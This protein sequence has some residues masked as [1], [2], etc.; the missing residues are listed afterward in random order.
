VSVTAEARQITGEA[1][2]TEGAF[3]D[4]VAARR[5]L[6][7]AGVPGLD[8][9]HP[10]NDPYLAAQCATMACAAHVLRA[11]VIRTSRFRG[12]AP[13]VAA[14][15]FKWLAD[16]DGEV[17]ARLRRLALRIA[18]DIPGLDADK[19]LAAAQGLRAAAPGR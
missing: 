9:L 11:D 18:C 8:P 12:G 5:T 16:H 13:P 10:V 2:V 7:W 6:W 17:D 4:E 1:R 15:F 3:A 14:D 19:V